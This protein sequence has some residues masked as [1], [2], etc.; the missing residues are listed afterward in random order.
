MWL[1]DSLFDTI[2]VLD[3]WMNLLVSLVGGRLHQQLHHSPIWGLLLD[4]IVSLASAVMVV[5]ESDQGYYQL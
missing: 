3:R 2:V 1:I 4:S 5:T